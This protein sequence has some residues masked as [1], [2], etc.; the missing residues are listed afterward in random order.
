MAGPNHTSV[1][2]EKNLSC[3]DNTFDDPEV[4]G[5]HSSRIN[6]W[7]CAKKWF[8]EME[9]GGLVQVVIFFVFDQKIRFSKKIFG[10]QNSV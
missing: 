5:H 2:I 10:R 7:Q 4:T 1:S 6:I 9:M 3:T 8:S